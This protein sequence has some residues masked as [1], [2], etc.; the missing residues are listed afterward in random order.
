MYGP[1]CTAAPGPVFSPTFGI[2][3]EGFVI[4]GSGIWFGVYGL[5]FKVSGLEYMVQGLGVRVY[6]SGFIIIQS[7]GFRV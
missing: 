7:S 2:G 1:A 3:V 6:I 4:W 5:G